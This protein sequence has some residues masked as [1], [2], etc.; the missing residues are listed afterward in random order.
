MLTP[1]IWP[2]ILAI[3]VR[4][5]SVET[6]RRVSAWSGG[7]H[8]AD[9]CYVRWKAVGAEVLH[10]VWQNAIN[11]R[12]GARDCLRTKA[13]S[14]WGQSCGWDQQWAHLRLNLRL[15]PGMGPLANIY[16]CCFEGWLWYTIHQ[17]FWGTAKAPQIVL[18]QLLLLGPAILKWMFHVACRPKQPDSTWREGS[19]RAVEEV[20]ETR[21]KMLST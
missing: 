1:N 16:V 6:F 14:F 5:A 4:L 11:G 12:L 2:Y 18:S 17:V 13:L 9:C 15:G 8:G 20:A 7:Q 21:L 10:R 3:P 19:R